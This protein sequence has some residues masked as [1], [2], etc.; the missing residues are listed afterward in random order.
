MLLHKQQ[1]H[2]GIAN[3]LSYGYEF[4]CALSDR[5]STASYS[6]RPLVTN[7]NMVHARLYSQRVVGEASQDPPGYA[8]VNYME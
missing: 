6:T 3:L 8:P 2:P 7:K 1:H 5:Q 4:P